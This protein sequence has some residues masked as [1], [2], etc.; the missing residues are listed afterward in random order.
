MS[1]AD[2]VSSANG[3]A[4]QARPA[5]FVHDVTA[6]AGRA[7]RAVPRDVPAVVPPVFIALFFFIVNIATLSK[8]THSGGGGFSYKAFSMPTAI[9]LGVT[10]VSRAPA[11][12]L[13]VQDGYL[14][15]LLMTPIR[16]LAI[17]LGHMVADVSVAMA[18]TLPILAVGFAIGVRFATGVLGVLAF[19]ALAALWSLAFSGFGYAIALKTGNPAAVNSAFLLFFPFLF[20]TT[21]YVPRSQLSGWLNTVA[22][23][24]PVTYLLQGLRSLVSQGWQ[25]GD[26]GKAAI[27]IAVLATLSMSLCLGALRGRTRRG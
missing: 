6:I 1:V 14:D 4:L 18:L 8:L 2:V 3:D 26:L 25:W 12:V 13:D 20:L 24:N 21:S 7:L 19:I 15:R 11:L 17:L 5:G 10:G 23:I 27:A 22:G 9:L 16:R